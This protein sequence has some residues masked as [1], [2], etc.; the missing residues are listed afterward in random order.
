MTAHALWVHY[1]CDENWCLL[2]KVP[3][4]LAIW[5]L[6]CLDK[7]ISQKDLGKVFF[8]V[9]AYNRC[10]RWTS[11]ISG[12]YRQPN[13][14]SLQREIL[15]HVMIRTFHPMLNKVFF[16]LKIQIR[17]RKSKKDNGRWMS[18][19]NYKRVYYDINWFIR[20][21]TFLTWQFLAVLPQSN[22]T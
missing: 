19:K 14:L 2:C 11:P 3:S 4:R 7:T 8:M 22:I 15:S 16:C 5:I 1:E 9:H 12:W 18:N 6:W 21:E 13:I 17:H 10:E 20:D